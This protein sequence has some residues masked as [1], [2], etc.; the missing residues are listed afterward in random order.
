MVFQVNQKSKMIKLGNDRTCGETVEIRQ[1]Q[2]Q[3]M[4]TRTEMGG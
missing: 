2:G 1:Q 4:S 3:H